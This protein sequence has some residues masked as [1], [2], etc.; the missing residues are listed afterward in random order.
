MIINRAHNGKHIF[1][2]DLNGNLINEWVSNYDA[3]KNLKIPQQHIARVLKGQRK[4]THGFI[5]S[6][7]C[8][9]NGIEKYDKDKKAFYRAVCK[10]SKDG[11]FISEYK[12][13]EDAQKSINLKYGISACC[14]GEFKT[15]GGYQWKYKDDPRIIDSIIKIKPPK[16]K[17][18][19][20]LPTN[21]K[22]AIQMT[23]QDEELCEYASLTEASRKT[24]SNLSNIHGCILGKQKSAGGYHWKYKE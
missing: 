14:R 13:I 15:A 2:Y 12:T 23:L 9:A 21:A 17:K 19:R 24:G 16:T 18:P 3:A 22:K 4:M 1:Q 11:T 5:F 8:F 6:Y 7:D 20:P 10:Y